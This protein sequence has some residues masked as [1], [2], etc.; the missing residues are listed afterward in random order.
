MSSLSCTDFFRERYVGAVF[1]PRVGENEF[2]KCLLTDFRTSKMVMN[3]SGHG[4]SAVREFGEALLWDRPELNE[5]K[6][7]PGTFRAAI[8]AEIISHS[9]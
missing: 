1:V 3:K 9:V 5:R 6:S 4:S 2:C 8:K 7:F